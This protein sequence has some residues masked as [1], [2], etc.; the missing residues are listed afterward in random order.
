MDAHSP[1]TMRSAHAATTAPRTSWRSRVR[2]SLCYAW[3][4]TFGLAS[5]SAAPK[6]W[7]VFYGVDAPPELMQGHDVVVVDPG[8]KGDIQLLKARGAKVLAYVSLGEVAERRAH[9]AQAKARGLL[10]TEN[11]NWPGAWMVDLRSPDWHRLVIDHLTPK[12][13]ARGFDGLFLDT[14][15][16]ALHLERT[17]P[18]T[19]AGMTAAAT[20]LIRQLH[21]RHPEARLLLNGGLPLVPAIRGAVDW[22]A[23]EST[24]LAYDFKTK[25]SRPQPQRDTWLKL[26]AKAKR[27]NPDLVVFTLDYVDPSEVATVRGVYAAQRKAGFVPYVS[28]IALN[29][30][31]PEPE[32]AVDDP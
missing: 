27:E 10:V 4:A 16:S 28:T 13:L 12:L 5:C 21:A 20:R 25:R 7:V 8:Y 11:P 17:R 9:F 30:V 6:S 3:L 1:H 14:I 32:A 19:H 2:R 22:I 23:V 31:V 18:A 26:L 29:R 24:F 15:D